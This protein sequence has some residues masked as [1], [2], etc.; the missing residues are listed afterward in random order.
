MKILNEFTIPK[1]E[2]RSFEIRKGQTLRII[3]VEGSQG[4]D[5]I[6]FNHDDLRESLSAWLTRHLSGNFTRAT[7]IYSKLPA[8]NVMFSVLTDLQDQFWL[9]PGRCNILTY[10]L[11]Y[12][13]KEYHKN[14]Q[15]ILA[16][17]IEPYGMTQW[18]VPEVLN[19][20]TKGV[21]HRDGS[22]QLGEPQVK[23]GDCIELLAEM[24]CLVAISACPDEL[25]AYNGYAPKPLK[26][27][28][29]E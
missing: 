20:F 23:K 10:Q 11:K 6:A 13:V 9:T 16:K 3:Q 24:D 29:I 26:I 19:M 2:G 14:C 4:A 22:Y 8:G 28:I 1:C 5:M 27:Q 18:D 25:G 7:K 21:L 15:D 12:G 17:C